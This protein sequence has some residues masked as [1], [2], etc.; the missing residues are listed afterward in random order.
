MKLVGFLGI[1]VMVFSLAAC[2]QKSGGTKLASAAESS[3]RTIVYDELKKDVEVGVDSILNK[4]YLETV[5][6]A[7]DMDPPAYTAERLVAG[8]DNDGFRFYVEVR[9]KMNASPD[10]V[11]DKIVYNTPLILMRPVTF[12]MEVES[13]ELSSESL[14]LDV[15][16]PLSPEL[17]KTLIDDVLR[18]ANQK[19][20]EKAHAKG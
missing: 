20:V 18:A 11:I 12:E 4:R 8:Q 6:D 7:S 2:S 16:C 3:S 13:L 15:G 5:K 9:F 10:R 19:L 1:G 14:T 17:V